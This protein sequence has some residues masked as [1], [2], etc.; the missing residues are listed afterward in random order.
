MVCWLKDR[1]LLKGQTEASLDNGDHIRRDAGQTLGKPGEDGRLGD[2]IEALQLSRCREIVLHCSKIKPSQ[3]YYR[4]EKRRE[5]DTD[6]NQDRDAD[7]RCPDD[8][9]DVSSKDLVDHVN[10]T[11][12]ERVCWSRNENMNS[13]SREKRFNVLEHA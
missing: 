5:T 10:C 13:R 6:D 1:I 8:V 11:I 4:E 3:R 2:R 9:F 7:Q 12:S